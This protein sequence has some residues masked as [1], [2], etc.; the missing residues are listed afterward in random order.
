[1]TNLVTV[2]ATVEYIILSLVIINARQVRSSVSA[3]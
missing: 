2:F 3:Y 1:M